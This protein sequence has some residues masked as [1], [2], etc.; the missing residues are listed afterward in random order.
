MISL[1]RAAELKAEDYFTR[2]GFASAADFL[3]QYRQLSGV[4]LHQPEGNAVCLNSLARHPV[5]A[6]DRRG[7]WAARRLIPEG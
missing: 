6:G 4:V 1:R 3:K 7:D 2:R 5:A